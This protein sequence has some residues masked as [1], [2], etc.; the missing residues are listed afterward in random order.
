[1]LDIEN[2]LYVSDMT[3][4]KFLDLLFEDAWETANCKE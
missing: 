4:S 1:M 2:N 3:N